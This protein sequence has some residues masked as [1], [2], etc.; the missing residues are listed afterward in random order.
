[1][2]RFIALVAGFLLFAALGSGWSANA[3][4]LA[5]VSARNHHANH[6]HAHKAG[7]R[8]RQKRHR[9]A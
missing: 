8:H 7:K 2:K 4:S 3:P 5:R 6:H 9:T 1:M